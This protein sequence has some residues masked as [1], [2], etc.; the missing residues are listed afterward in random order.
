MTTDI[1]ERVPASSGELIAYGP[2]PDHVGELRLPAGTGPHPVFIGLHGGFWRARYD[3]IHFGHACEALT[4][5]GFATWNVEFR[6]MGDG[7]G[8][9]ATFLDVGAAADAL[10]DLAARYPLDL[11][12]VYAIGH[13]A[14]GHLALWLAGR[15]R[16]PRTSELWR[17]DPLPLAGA[18]ALAGAVDL[19]RTWELAL[20]DNATGLL[21][22]GAPADVPVRYAAGSPAELLPLGV[23]QAL[24][25]GDR[26]TVVPIEVSR[27]YV[28]A[29][30]A[31]GDDARLVALPGVD[32]F[33]VI[34]PESDAWPAVLDAI[35]ALA[36]N[37]QRT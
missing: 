32:H 16:I 9:P 34:D 35:L 31:A 5:R 23:P 17:D 13:S 11:G 24:I 29:A 30:Q 25:S 12:R 28:M 36:W 3:R 2:E 21:M 33:A 7:G 37:P 4:A 20:S 15:G 22:G 10:R 26:D 6:R 14:G 19:R 1:L 27:R 18:V 8:W